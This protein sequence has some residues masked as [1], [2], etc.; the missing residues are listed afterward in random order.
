MHKR[1]VLRACLHKFTAS[2]HLTGDIDHQTDLRPLLLFRQ[3]VALFGRGKA[4]L[5][6]SENQRRLAEKEQQVD[7]L[8]EQGIKKGEAVKL[9]KAEQQRL[10]DELA[11]ENQQLETLIQQWQGLQRE[12]ALTFDAGYSAA[13]D[14]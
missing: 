12:L 8:R 4:A 5:E 1:R 9:A 2:P 6:L 11:V 7:A 14:A 10:R 13:L 3:A